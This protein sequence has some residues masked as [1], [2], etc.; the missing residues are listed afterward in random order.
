MSG[1]AKI[2]ERRKFAK[3]KICERFGDHGAAGRYGVSSEARPQ[4]CPR[5]ESGS[6]EMRQMKNSEFFTVSVKR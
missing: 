2:L 3:E 1:F 4:A 6:R 5:V